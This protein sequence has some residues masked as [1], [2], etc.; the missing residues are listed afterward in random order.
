MLAKPASSPIAV[1]ALLKP[2]LSKMA[3][4]SLVLSFFSL[5]PPFGIAAVALGHVSRKKIAGSGGRLSGTGV[6]FAALIVGYLQLTL[7]AILL[8]GALGFL[9]RMNQELSKNPDTRAAL[10]ARLKFGDPHKLH[11]E[12]SAKHQQLAEDALRLVRTRQREY[13]AAHPDEGY[14]CRFDQLGDPAAGETELGNLIRNSHY[15]T[16][17]YQCRMPNELRYVVLS[18]PRSDSNVTDAPLYCLDSRETIY[19]YRNDQARDVVA[20]VAGGRDPQ[21]CSSDGERIE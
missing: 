10:I 21:L 16:Q 6:A 5:F 2:Q 18:V 17:I 7:V 12:D 9:N 15:Q 14:A 19:K 13:L 4:A 11:P 3:L 8:I 1:T 20:S